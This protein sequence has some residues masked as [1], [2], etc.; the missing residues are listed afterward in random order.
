MFS[1]TKVLYT[2]VPMSSFQA[3]E[4]TVSKAT[5]VERVSRLLRTNRRRTKPYLVRR[6]A[7]LEGR[8]YPKRLKSFENVSLTELSTDQPVAISE[9]MYRNKLVALLSMQH[10]MRIFTTVL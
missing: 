1:L 3:M 8:R 7:S 4:V 10:F 2:A 5:T 6:V 9:W